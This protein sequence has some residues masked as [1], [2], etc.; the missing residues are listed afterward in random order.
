[1]EIGESGTTG[2]PNRN[3]KEFPDQIM[4]RNPITRR[5]PS[6]CPTFGD[7]TVNITFSFPYFI[8]TRSPVIM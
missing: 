3:R 2:L 4:K 1:M 8:S 7:R 6:A 5:F